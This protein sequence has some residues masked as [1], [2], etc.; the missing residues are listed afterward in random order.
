MKYAD[1]QKLHEASLITDEQR[2]NIIIHFD[3][4]E[5]GGKFLAIVSMIGAALVTAGIILLISANWNE[6]PRGAKIATGIIL[7]LGAHGAG[8]WLR[9]A[10]GD[11]RKTGE[12]LHLVGAGLFLGNIALLGQI[13]N[14]V[15]RPPNAILLWWAGIAALPWILRSQ[16]LHILSLLAFGLWFGLEI[17]ERG[18]WFYFG[19]S[20]NQILLYALL[21]LVYLGAGYA[22]RRTR[23]AEFSGPTEQIGLLGFLAF[24]YPLT[25][26]IFGHT[27]YAD[28]QMVAAWVFPAM[29]GAA[30]AGC[31]FG[32][33]T[34]TGL[35]RQWRWTWA[36]TLAGAVALL[37]GQMYFAP[38]QRWDYGWHDFGYHWIAAIGLFVFCLLQIQVGIQERAPFMVN[39]GIAFIALDIIATYIRLIG[40]MARTG[41]MFLISGVFLIV[42]GIYLEKKRRRLMAQIK[43]SAV[44]RSAS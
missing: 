40:S 35:T 2:Q 25:W 11:Y 14:L 12:A 33:S 41:L 10:R 21:G 3:L 30:V 36:L 24:A 7:M 17:N 28:K 20:E 6:I 31:A 29:C 39:L 15:S 26:G 9:E 23:Y 4:K 27:Y 32:V 18:S 5:E 44:E 19:N 42:F 13:Y 34:L 38:E 1:I 43:T 8:W 37:A 22:L 16:A